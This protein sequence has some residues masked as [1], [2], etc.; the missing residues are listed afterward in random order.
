STGLLHCT[1]TGWDD[2]EPLEEPQPSPSLA[3]IQAAQKRPVSQP[4][5]P[6]SHVKA[7]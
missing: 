4:I 5:P 1:S 3:N 2:L 7:P 6:A